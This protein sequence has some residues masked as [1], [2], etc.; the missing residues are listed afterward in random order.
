MP[1]Q[2]SASGQPMH[3]ERQDAP[4]SWQQGSCDWQPVPAS[5][6]QKL[7]S[8][9]QYL[10]SAAPAKQRSRQTTLDG[11][12]KR[13]ASTSFQSPESVE[14]PSNS[15]RRVSRLA[16]GQPSVTSGQKLPSSV[17]GSTGARSNRAHLADKPRSGLSPCGNVAQVLDLTQDLTQGWEGRAAT[18]TD[19]APPQSGSMTTVSECRKRCRSLLQSDSQVVNFV[20]DSFVDLT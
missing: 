20:T 2:A 5:S 17:T 11:G 14:R 6:E 19:L 16:D 4:V 9:G 3:F 18:W 10:L 13:A 12:L 7:Q 8:R 15:V 1:Q